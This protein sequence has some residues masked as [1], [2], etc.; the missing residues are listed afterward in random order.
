AALVVGEEAQGGSDRNAAHRRRRMK[1]RRHVGNPAS[2]SEAC[3]HRRVQMDDVR[4][5]ADAWLAGP[6]EVVGDAGEGVGDVIDDPAVLAQV[7]AAGGQLRGV[8][9]GSRAG[10]RV[11]FDPASFDTAEDLR[12]RSEDDATRSAHE[13][14]PA[15]RISTFECAEPYLRSDGRVWLALTR[16]TDLPL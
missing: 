14:G 13:K 6:M 9:G 4:Q 7:L 5:R 3:D 11:G 8:L 1:S 2:G 12:R 10:E 15:A 16:S